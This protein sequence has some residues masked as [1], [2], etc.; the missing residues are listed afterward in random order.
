MW[1]WSLDGDDPLEKE[2]A[3]PS[4]MLAWK[5]PW[6]EEPGRLQSV[7]SQRVRQDGAT[8]HALL[9][10]PHQ[11]FYLILIN[12]SMTKISIL[13][14]SREE[15]WGLGGEFAQDRTASQW[16]SWHL[17][18][19]SGTFLVAQ[20]LRFYPPNA[21]DLGSGPGQGTRSRMSQLKISHAAIKT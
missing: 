5:I 18:W 15:N 17:K 8:E 20:W 9:C 21:Q 3:N 6:T 11:F 19:G 13:P 16:Q 2:M 12:K 14:F 7:G 10:T 4:S 1:V